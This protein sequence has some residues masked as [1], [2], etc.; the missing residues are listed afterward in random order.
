MRLERLI[1]PGL[2]FLQF[3]LCIALVLLA[4]W[5]Q[6]S[7][8]EFGVTGFELNRIE[9]TAHVWA[10]LAC[11][12]LG[13]LLGLWAWRSLGLTRLR[14][15]PEPGAT[16]QLITTGPYHWVR[17]PMYVGVLLL[18]LGVVLLSTNWLS[19]NWPSGLLWLA[20]LLVLD[21]KAARE[22]RLL[23]QAFPDYARYRQRTGRFIPPVLVGRVS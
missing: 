12:A 11:M 23:E 14:I 18:M 6:L 21:R 16:A 20:L 7:A 13:S 19:M 17:H 22:E 15:M 9:I 10:G 8:D 2:V 4:P 5:Y 3:A 1:S